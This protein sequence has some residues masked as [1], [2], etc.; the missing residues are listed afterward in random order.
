[1]SAALPEAIALVATPLLIFAARMVDVSLATIRILLISRGLKRVA[2]FVGFVEILI[3]LVALGQVVQ[4]LDRWINYVAYAGGFAAGTW[5][6]IVLE[7]KL[8]L[9]L[10][11]VR[12]ITPD[13]ATD[14]IERLR[15]EKFGVTS[16]A[17]RGVTGQVR[18][19]ITVIQRKDLRKVEEIVHALHP[20]A[21]LSISD[22]RAV[23]EGFFGRG[24]RGLPLETGKST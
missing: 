8:A 23:S 14:L 19:I 20:H 12:I 22:V 2:P 11:A 10:L 15:S 1:M 16:V 4:H 7:S 3:W 21:F 13:D 17:A 18:L 9:G 5:A 6:G 24:G